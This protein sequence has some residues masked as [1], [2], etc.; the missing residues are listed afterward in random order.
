MTDR[1]SRQNLV[2]SSKKSNW[3]IVLGTIGCACIGFG[4]VWSMG[5]GRSVDSPQVEAID[6]PVAA[7]I[8]NAP[9]SLQSQAADGA[10]APGRFVSNDSETLP[11]ANAPGW[12]SN[13]S[14]TD[15]LAQ[16]NAFPNRP[17]SLDMPTTVSTAAVPQ[18]SHFSAGPQSPITA[19]VQAVSAASVSDPEPDSDS[20]HSDFSAAELPETDSTVEQTDENPNEPPAPLQPDADPLAAPAVL[21]AV[22]KAAEIPLPAATV[23]QTSPALPADPNIKTPTSDI[24]PPAPPAPP[25]ATAALPA[26]VLAKANTPAMS[27]SNALR[28]DAV[29]AVPF[30]AAPPLVSSQRTLAPASLAT[31]TIGSGS[32]G[33]GRPGPMQL[34]GVQT[35]QLT[36]EKRG[37]REVQVGKAARYEILVRNVG[38]ATAHAVTLRDTVPYGTKLI[39]TTPPASHGQASDSEFQAGSSAAG[40]LAW[41]IGSL[42]PGAEARTSMEVM[43]M[44]EGEVGSVASVNFRADA[45]VRS[46]ATKPDL[47]LEATAPK[48]VLLG[49][50]VQLTIK[51]SNPG[52]GVATGVVLEGTLPEGVTHKAGRE[53]EFD[54][55]Q[56]RPGESRTIDLVLDS[57]GPGVH[58]ARFIARADGQIEVEQLVRI[59]ITAPTLELSV[60]MPSRRYLQ[61]PATCVLSMANTGTAPA[62]G[63]ELAAQ[64]PQGMK[65]MRANNAGYY[66]ERQHRVLWN[67][68]EL[69][70]GEI[71]SVEVVVMPIDLGPQKI[72]VAARSAAGLSDQATHTVDVEG[73]AAL[74]FEVTDSEDPIEVDGMTEYVVRIG[75]QGTKSAS[76]VR[77]MVTLLGE[78][79]PVDAKGPVAHRVENLTILF[80]PLVKLSPSEDAVFRIRVRG[81]RAG[82]Q[83]MQVQLTSDDHPSPITKEEIT[84]VYADR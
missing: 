18:L 14:A 73:V 36:V 20:G 32:S 29:A 66:D 27:E 55:G 24:D 80:E 83:R 7:V 4:V 5:I 44:I 67:L 61:R 71:G 77:L 56:L 60:E 79:E 75:N 9:E 74:V 12:R 52:T 51:I 64:L 30:A 50:N 49:K 21:P 1:P 57:T 40:E 23:A 37:P 76:G 65:F 38:S 72:M 46:H 6:A 8:D 26:K 10:N 59:D 33:Q 41:T 62:K 31:S 45:S 42:A 58:A 25:V 22:S 63:V 35:P 70:A 13:A 54:V 81:R 68:E 47:R 82:D 3:P 19:D 17:A 84:H 11:A 16:G 48:P 78:L 69:P 34:E 15:P 43:P 53:L 39:A 2:V 28:A